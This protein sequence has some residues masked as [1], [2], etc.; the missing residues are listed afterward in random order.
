RLTR[1]TRDLDEGVVTAVELASPDRVEPG[2]A[3]FGTCGGCSLQ[4]LAPEAQ[5]RFKQKAMLDALERIGQVKPEEVAAPITGPV[6]AYRR[7]ARMGVKFV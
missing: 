5:L 7:R 6:W 1:K 4:H 2:C 3:H